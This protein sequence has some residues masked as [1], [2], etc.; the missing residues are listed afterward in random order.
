VAFF[1][2]VLIVQGSNTPVRLDWNSTR[3][4]SGDHAEDH[5]DSCAGR[6]QVQ[7]DVQH[8]RRRVML[9]EAP[10]R[11]TVNRALEQHPQE[12]RERHVGAGERSAAREIRL[13][14]EPRTDAFLA[15]GD[16]S[17]RPDAGWEAGRRR[18]RDASSMMGGCRNAGSGER[19]A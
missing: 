5:A 12:Q 15:D 9:D 8:A 3:R 2:F 7:H 14:R 18:A 19:S 16:G 6:H 11:G 4:P 10:V 17:D 1:A 13:E